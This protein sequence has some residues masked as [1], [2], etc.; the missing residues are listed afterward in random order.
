[1][2]FADWLAAEGAHNDLVSWV[3]ASGGDV[4]AVWDACPRGD[5]LLAMAARLGAEPR[6]LVLAASAA[7]RT[8]FELL[9]DEES[10]PAAAL[11]ALEAAVRAADATNTDAGGPEP[12]GRA[13]EEL[14]AHRAA[15]EAMAASAPD[16][17]VN[18]IAE[19][20]LAAI[21]SLEEP[22]AAAGAAAL[23]A[24]ASVFD[25]G[26]CAMMAALGYAQE[27]SA[28]AVRGHL[29]ATWAVSALERIQ[30]E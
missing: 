26:D 11:V 2:S 21:T 7:A 13:S 14:Q 9:P 1:M 22:G 18:V 27:M 5:W 20:V 30:G 16:P 25:A 29:E 28:K 23:A 12:E 6:A 15:V 8:A 3:R 4:G 10:R 24:Q 17:T 19:A